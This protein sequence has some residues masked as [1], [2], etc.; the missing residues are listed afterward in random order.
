MKKLIL[1]IAVAL[2][3]S[4]AISSCIE[5]CPKADKEEMAALDSLFDMAALD[6]LI[7]TV[8][9]TIAVDSIAP[10]VVK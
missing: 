9:D 4:V 7:D 2:F 6:S 8:T 5:H 10:E 3:A 1:V